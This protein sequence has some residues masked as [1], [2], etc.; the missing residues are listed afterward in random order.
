V[1][2][3][4]LYFDAEEKQSIKGEKLLDGIDVTLYSPKSSAL[5][6]YCAE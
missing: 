3:G 2:V 5:I 6:T 4:H 1:E